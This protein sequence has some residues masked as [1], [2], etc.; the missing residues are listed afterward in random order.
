[1]IWRNWLGYRDRK[2]ARLIKESGAVL[3]MQTASRA[4]IAKMEL[5]RLRKMKAATF[6]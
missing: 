1:M 5:I 6:V 4:F 3:K 2:K